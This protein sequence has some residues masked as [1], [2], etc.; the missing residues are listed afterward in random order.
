MLRN[1]LSLLSVSSGLLHLA[2]LVEASQAPRVT[3]V[4]P[5]DGD[6]YRSGDTVA[7]RWKADDTVV[8]PSFRLCVHGAQ[9]RSDH[10]EGSGKDDNDSD[11]GDDVP[12]GEAVWP[13]IE[14]SESDGSYLIQVALPNI[15]SVQ[16]CYL[17]MV[18]DFGH[19]MASPTFAFRPSLTKDVTADVADEGDPNADSSSPA[20]S[21]ASSSSSAPTQVL[22]S[23]DESRIP[24]PTAAYAVPLS[25]VLSVLLAAGGLSIRQR[26][27]L[28]AEREKEQEALKNRQTLSRHSTLSFSGFK[29]LGVGLPQGQDAEGERTNETQAQSRST[30]VSLMREWQ[31]DVSRYQ[32]R[33]VHDGHHSVAADDND[34]DT[35]VARTDDGRGSVVT[36]ASSTARSSSSKRFAQHNREPRHITREPFHY[37]GSTSGRTRPRHVTTTI[38]ASVFRAAASPILPPHRREELERSHGHGRRGYQLRDEFYGPPKEA[39]YS[40]A[41]DSDAGSGY[42][43]HEDDWETM[44]KGNDDNERRYGKDHLNASVSDAVISQYYDFSPIPLSPAPPSR[45]AFSVTAPER[46]HVRRYAENTDYEKALGPSPRLVGRDLYETVASKLSRA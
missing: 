44:P 38:P 40:V 43:Y 32:R 6:S 13:T 8:S 41:R 33:H 42:Y 37:A 34:D 39:A 27:K 18:D 26:R 28:R 20:S 3:W 22:P 16:H 30:S 21:P 2:S 15:T 5:S 25:L 46:L 45:E 24:A 7:G 14:Q 35:Y 29:A 4:S 36:S 31:R 11:E 9:R 10:G 23:I 12:C 17:E 19:K 1:T